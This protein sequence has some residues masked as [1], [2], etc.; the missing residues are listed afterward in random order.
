MVNNVSVRGLTFRA[1]GV[2]F[3][4]NGGVMRFV[5]VVVGY[6]LIGVLWTLYLNRKETK[7]STRLAVFTALF[8]L[9]LET[10]VQLARLK[11]E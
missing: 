8:W 9:P 4:N 2:T 7:M 11:G 1:E 6:V 5:S 3:V 10:M